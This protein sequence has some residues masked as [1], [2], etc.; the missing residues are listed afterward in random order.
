MLFSPFILLIAGVLADF[1]DIACSPRSSPSKAVRFSFT[2]TLDFPVVIYWNDFNC[3]LV[4]GKTLAPEKTVKTFQGH[5]YLAKTLNNEPVDSFT[6]KKRII[7]RLRTKKW[8]Q[9][10]DIIDR[11]RKQEPLE[12]IEMP[13]FPALFASRLRS[14][15]SNEEDQETRTSQPASSPPAQ[16]ASSPPPVFTSST[17]KDAEAALSESAVPDLSAPE[18]AVSD[19]SASESA[20]PVPPVVA[21]VANLQVLDDHNVATGIQPSTGSPVVN[22]VNNMLTSSGSGLDDVAPSG[23]QIVNDGVGDVVFDDGTNIPGTDSSVR[24]GQSQQSSS[25]M[26]I[27]ASIGGIVLVSVLVSIGAL[28]RTRK[29]RS[30][31]APVIT[32]K[33]NTFNRVFRNSSPKSPVETEDGGG[34]SPV[35]Y[36]FSVGSSVTLSSEFSVD[37]I[38]STFA[39]FM[40]SSSSSEQSS[41]NR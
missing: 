30:S 33:G 10:W 14:P 32:T 16:S 6:V 25:P 34:E 21:D 22:R 28:L 5:T 19:P 35:G 23:G 29:K 31:A 15:K 26:F 18:S 13:K 4:R 38:V 37:D 36:S 12:A 11:R 8:S 24:G 40:S 20:V 7:S 9:H 27:G 39:R 41:V 1:T 17:P 3:N 2:N